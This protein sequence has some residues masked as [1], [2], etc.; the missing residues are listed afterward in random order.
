VSTLIANWTRAWIDV[1]VIVPEPLLLV[2]TVSHIAGE[3]AA[4]PLP[5]SILTRIG[6]VD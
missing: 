2:P 6:H 4:E 3:V 5:Y 1:P